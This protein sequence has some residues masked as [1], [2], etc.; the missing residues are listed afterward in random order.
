[1]TRPPSDG[2]YLPPPPPFLQQKFKESGMQRNKKRVIMFKDIWKC[3][4][5][6]SGISVWMEILI[7]VP[8]KV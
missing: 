3:E 8:N 5:I 4:S 7:P 2:A 1:M 6:M